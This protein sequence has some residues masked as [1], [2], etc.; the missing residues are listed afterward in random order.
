VPGEPRSQ[1]ATGT[2]PTL[3]QLT[4]TRQPIDCSANCLKI[5][6]QAS[7]C[8][9]VDL[10]GGLRVRAGLTTMGPRELGGTRLRRVLLA[11]LLHRGSPVSRDR[12]VSLLWE[13]SPPPR[14]AKNTIESYVCLLRKKLQPCQDAR[15]SLITTVAGGYAIDM[16]RVD[17][18]LARYERLMS[19]ALRPDTAATVALPMLR[20]AI[21]LS[22]SAL[23][24]EEV[25]CEWLDDARRTHNQNVRQA[26][27]AAADKVAELP[28]D[29]A[30]RWARL[31]LD[32]DALDESAWHALLRS[33]EARGQHAEGLRAY[34]HCRRLFAEELGCAPGPGLQQ[35][36][37][38]LL[39][40]ANEDDEGLSRLIDAVVRLHATSQLSADSP[41]P[42]RNS[43]RR[44]A[45]A[46]AASAPSVVQARQALEHLLSKAGGDRQHRA[47]ALGA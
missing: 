20:H 14:G 32:S 28:C 7:A 25:D 44:D 39:R 36:Y 23:L 4:S 10:L 8:V 42:A 11:L 12:L 43:E 38:R 33:M 6:D 21:T 13:G 5:P 45:N 9:A 46:P 17:L 16:S 24:P 22:E 31:A 41:E 35:L 18:D 34:D 26:L 19:A 37:V 15:S 1:L 47:V 30:Q 40:G 29:S 27:I 2:A 3:L